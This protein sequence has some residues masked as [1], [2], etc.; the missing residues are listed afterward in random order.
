MNMLNTIRSYVYSIFDAIADPEE[1]RAAYIH[2]FGVAQC[3]ALL[4]AK[5]GLDAELAS[6]IGLLHDV[7]SYKTGHKRLHGPDGAEMLRVAFKYALR[8][9]FSDGEQT[10]VKSAVHHHSDKAHVHDA[11]DELLKDCDVLQHYLFDVSSDEFAGPRLTNV[12]RELSVA[13]PQRPARALL[14]TRSTE[15]GRAALA[16][17]AEDL[18]G[19]Q[20]VGERSNAEYTR[21]IRYFPEDS[22]FDELRHAWCAAFVYHCCQEAGLKLPLRAPHTARMLADTRFACVVA[23]Y[24]WGARKGYLHYEKDGFDPLRG[25]IVIYNGIIPPER[26]PP[27]GAWCDHIGIVLACGADALTAA[28]G[29]RDHTN[30]SGIVTR[31]RD[32]TIGC[33]L[34]IP[35]NCVYDDWKVDFKSG[36]IRMEEYGGDP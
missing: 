31:Q 11:Y 30:A 35:E 15:F 33:Y 6:A 13:V 10:I 1:R 36:E 29:N 16:D 27:D 21:V 14:Y 18:A 8:G 2:S 25:D 32:Q 34:R 20:I 26:K 3:C 17:I 4:A 22:A 7:Y 12:G 28:E 5:R 23:W 19:R 9:V 24:E